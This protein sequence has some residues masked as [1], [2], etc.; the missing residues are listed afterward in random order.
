LLDDP[1]QRTTVLAH[2]LLTFVADRLGGR[3]PEA[4]YRTRFYWHRRLR[5]THERLEH[6]GGPCPADNDAELHLLE[7]GAALGVDWDHLEPLQ[8]R[9]IADADAALGPGPFERPA[10]A[11]GDIRPLGP[12]AGP[13]GAWAVRRLDDNGNTFVVREGLAR[14]EAERLAAEF[15]ARGHKQTYWAEPQ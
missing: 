13:V 6:G 9:A 14:A 15:E 4:M 12:S 7:D 2:L 11:C 5:R 3:P 10:F 1:R 8:A